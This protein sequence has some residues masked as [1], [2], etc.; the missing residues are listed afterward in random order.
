M[1]F[2][3]GV[4]LLAWPVGYWLASEWLADF[5]YQTPLGWAVMPVASIIVMGFV[6]LA[7]GLSSARAAAMRPGLA[8]R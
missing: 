1:L 7:V 4:S 3:G 8:L 6:A 5:K 2:A